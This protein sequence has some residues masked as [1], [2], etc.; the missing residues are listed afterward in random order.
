MAEIMVREIDES[1]RL[2]IPKEWRKRLGKKFVLRFEGN[3]IRMIAIK[4]VNLTKY[5]DSIE[6]DLKSDLSDWH[7]VRRELRCGL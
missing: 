1:G 2:V 3:Q 4:P 7:S 5:F 6:V